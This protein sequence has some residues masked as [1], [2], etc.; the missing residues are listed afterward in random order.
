MWSKK[1]Q[2]HNFP[3][4]GCSLVLY[5]L[6]GCWH[7]LS[8]LTKFS[9]GQMLVIIPPQQHILVKQEKVPCS[10]SY[11]KIKVIFF[12][13]RKSQTVSILYL[14]LSTHTF[15]NMLWHLSHGAKGIIKALINNNNLRN[16]K[17][18]H[19]EEKYILGYTSSNCFLTPRKIP[20]SYWGGFTK[21]T[22]Q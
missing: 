13:L 21:I 19:W 10:W 5:Q 6:L 3:S 11:L 17:N 4:V 18:R 7:A 9:K 14:W 8:I 22:S 15:P 16:L 12:N 2:I 1:P 20:G